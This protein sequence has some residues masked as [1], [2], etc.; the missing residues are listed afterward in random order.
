M[1][2]TIKDGTGDGYRA[3]V[4]VKNRLRTFATTESGG[5]E[6]SIDGEL[7]N[8][9]TGTIPLTTSNKSHL[10]YAKNNDSVP[11]VIDRVFYNAGASAGGSGDLLAE[12]VANPST[13]TLVSSGADL[14]PYNLNF[15]SSK[16]LLGVIK[17]GVEGS[18]LTDGEVRVSTII[19]AAGTRVLISFDSIILEP[20]SS[21]GISFTPQ[22]G[23]TLTN[24]QVGINIYRFIQ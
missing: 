11:W 24:V 9:N 2:D 21:I 1:T 22:L 15:G 19:P 20:G 14:P 5:T 16:T 12:V 23:N 18:T 6:A 7:Y 3:Q 13:G 4:D 10:L 8:I 17:K